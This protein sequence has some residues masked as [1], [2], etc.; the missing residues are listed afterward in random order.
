MAFN[1]PEEFKGPQEGNL[2][3]RVGNK[4]L[5]LQGL[6]LLLNKEKEE[7]PPAWF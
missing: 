1:S 3:Y 6:E 5:A 4:H 2:F 7:H